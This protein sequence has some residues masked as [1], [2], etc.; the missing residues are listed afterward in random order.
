MQEG[1]LSL[2]QMGKT[3]AAAMRLHQ[4]GVPSIT[5]LT[6]PTTGGVY[7]SFASQGD[8]LFAEPGALIGFAGPRV[9]EQLTG[10]APPAGTH[11]AEFLL[12]HGQVD[13]VVDRA[14]LRGIL[15]TLLQ[16]WHNR[17]QAEPRA[18]AVPYRPPASPA[19]S[20][21]QEVLLARRDDRPTSADYIR[22]LMP[23]FIE[24]H[25]DR[26]YGDDAAVIAGIGDLAGMTI[27]A[28]GQERGHGDP[29]RNGGRLGPEGFRKAA[30]IM[31]LAAE[32]RLPL[33][34]FIDTP[35]AHLDYDSEARGLAGALSSCL[36]N[37]SVLPVPVVSVV[38]GEGGSGPALAL[39]VA[40]RILMQEHAVYS[41]IAPEGAAAIVHRDAARA[42]EIADALKMT[43]YDC[44]LLGVVD[45]IVPE[46]ENG[47]HADPEYASLLLRA[48]VVS[49]LGDLR[50]RD[51]RRL[52]EERWRKFRR[53][54]EFG[55]LVEAAEGQRAEAL[56][57][58]MRHAFG[59]LGQLR[60]RWPSRS[61]G[62]QS[63]T[64]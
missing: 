36:A 44:L 23:Q 63:A 43:A 16:L 35:G 3:A 19:P 46:P 53:M 32:L 47:A 37:M 13:A 7:A 57:T 54:G 60:E 27:F 20:A 48:E 15:A 52:V 11:T 42:Q 56:R 22:R 64:T 6:N 61:D 24:L 29:A 39:G 62:R 25:G 51:A 21:W 40:D 34:T 18:V 26:V 30:R 12:Q 45:G 5:V 58:A 55:R 50:K 2:V 41:V 8:F 59:S 49:A 10:E 28:I 38:I 33:I 17:G 14:R 9:I 4:A 31:R 1:M